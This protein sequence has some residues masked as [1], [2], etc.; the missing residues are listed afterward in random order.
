MNE[1]ISSFKKPGAVASY[2][3]LGV[4]IYGAFNSIHAVTYSGLLF[5]VFS[6]SVSLLN[7]EITY[8]KCKIK[9][10]ISVKHKNTYEKIAKIKINEYELL[11]YELNKYMHSLAHEVRDCVSDLRAIEQSKDYEEEAKQRI[12]T[13]TERILNYASTSFTKLLNCECVASLMLREQNRTLTTV[14][15]SGNAS[16]ERTGRR[17]GSL[18][19]NGGIAGKAFET[20]DVVEWKIGD[21]LFTPIRERFEDFYRS[22]MSIPFRVGY[23]YGGIL[24]I[25]CMDTNAFGNGN[26]NNFKKNCGCAFADS[27]GS[28]TEALNLWYGE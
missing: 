20:K 5:L 8:Q 16:R 21:P 3:G 4:S 23:E 25:D 7:R 10:G 27:I 17:S 2:L 11:I 28:I 22:G 15:Y 19:I 14:C 6:L 1:M 24:N 18:A 13:S 26:I 9:F 12:A